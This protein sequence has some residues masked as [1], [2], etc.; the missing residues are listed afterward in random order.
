MMVKLPDDRVWI[1]EH[2]PALLPRFDEKVESG[3]FETENEK[4][5]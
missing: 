5:D 2:L 1:S 3:E 4:N